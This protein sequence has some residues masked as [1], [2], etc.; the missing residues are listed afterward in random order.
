MMT[1]F[2]IRRPTV[3]SLAKSE[4]SW[5]VSSVMFLRLLRRRSARRRCGVLRAGQA[6]RYRGRWPDLL[7]ALR[8]RHSC[9]FLHL[10]GLDISWTFLAYT[11][12]RR[13]L[14]PT[15]ESGWRWCNYAGDDIVP[16]RQA[17]SLA[18]REHVGQ[19]LTSHGLARFRPMADVPTGRAKD[20]GRGSGLRACSSIWS[21]GMQR[22]LGRRLRR[23]ARRR[24][25]FRSPVV[26][27]AG[28]L[29]RPSSR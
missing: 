5:S 7:A 6:V 21:S 2:L 18:R 4:R 3:S 22:R 11:G 19:E 20:G 9:V 17:N 26:A 1:T 23:R 25:A 12:R 27:G 24:A 13:H 28:R 15:S 10:E 29:L 16:V 8:F 14:T